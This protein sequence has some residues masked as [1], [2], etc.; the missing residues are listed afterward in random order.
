MST[1]CADCHGAF[2]NTEAYARHLPACNAVKRHEAQVA[3]HAGGD[4]IEGYPEGPPPLRGYQG[5]EARSDAKH[6]MGE[7]AEQ[8]TDRFTALREIIM[9]LPDSLERQQAMCRLEESAYWST[10]GLTASA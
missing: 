8:V 10:M 6:P 7:L 2:P 3:E 1:P 5:Q 9:Q 4:E